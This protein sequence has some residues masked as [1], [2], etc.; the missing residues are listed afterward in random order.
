MT[1]HRW[2][3][4]SPRFVFNA[5]QRT[6]M[7]FAEMKSIGEA[8]LV[9]AVNLSKSGLSF[10]ISENSPEPEEGDT[11]KVEFTPPGRAPIACFATVMRVEEI[12][13]WHPDRGDSSRT[14]VSAKFRHL[15]IAHERALRLALDPRVGRDEPDP[16][17]KKRTS[18]RLKLI[19]AAAALG[20][21]ALALAARQ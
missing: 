19:A 8:R 5:D 21:A 18:T 16:Q 20:L 14:K 12:A 13:S 1:A 3:V 4:R 7:R 11:I 9:E 15:L 6:F 10:F 2:L 17:E